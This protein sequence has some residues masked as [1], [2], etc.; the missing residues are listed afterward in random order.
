MPKTE[1][2]R[3][4]ASDIDQF[5]LNQIVRSDLRPLSIFVT[6]PSNTT[7]AC[8]FSSRTGM[9][10]HSARRASGVHITIKHMAAANC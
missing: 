7:A 9:T 3:K 8:R 10:T 2:L 4:I 5:P 1:D 6:T